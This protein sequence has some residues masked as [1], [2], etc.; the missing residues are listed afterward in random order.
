[1]KQLKDESNMDNL[2]I[3]DLYLYIEATGE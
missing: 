1:L 2:A 3:L